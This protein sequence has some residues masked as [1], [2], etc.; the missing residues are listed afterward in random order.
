MRV[1]LFPARKTHLSCIVLNFHLWSFWLYHI[2]PHYLQ[3]A[4]FSGKKVLKIRC[5]LIFPTALVWNVPHSRKNSAIYFIIFFMWNSCYSCQILI[6]IL[7]SSTEFG[8]L[9]RYKF[10]WKSFHWDTSFSV[11]MDRHNEANSRLGNF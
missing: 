5:A 7:I 8:K 9:L 1:F 6:K 11:R 4:R 10:S 2:F 3:N